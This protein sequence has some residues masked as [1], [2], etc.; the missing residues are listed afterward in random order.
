MVL[1]DDFK[2]YEL[3][4]DD[5]DP[6]KKDVTKS[7]LIKIINERLSKRWT[8][9]EYSKGIE[10]DVQPEWKKILREDGSTLWEY[11]K[12]GWKAMQYQQCDQKGK[13]KREWLSF[14]NLD[15]KGKNK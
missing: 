6:P 5:W 9:S 12:L 7:E 8:A 3:L 1:V 10:M 14:K 2:D 15:Y 4:I 11:T 13:I